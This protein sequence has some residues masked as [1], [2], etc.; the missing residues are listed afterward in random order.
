[1][2]EEKEKCCDWRT[3][4][5]CPIHRACRHTFKLERIDT[6]QTNIRSGSTGM[7]YK[8]VGHVICEKCGLIIKQDI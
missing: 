8:K 4:E 3:R 6:E 5:E 7:F 2:K 1:M